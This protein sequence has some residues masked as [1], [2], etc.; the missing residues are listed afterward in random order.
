M[1]SRTVIK[2]VSA[3]LL[4]GAIIG[5]GVFAY[6]AGVAQGYA[7]NN[8]SSTGEPSQMPLP[9]YPSFYGPHFY[10]FGFLGC[11]VPFFL[12]FLIF[13]AMRGLFWGGWRDWG[14]MHHGPWGRGRPGQEM[15]PVFDEWHRQAHAQ[16]TS[17]A[18]EK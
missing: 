2:I 17:D 10:G 14:T 5:L 13:F 6:N 1:N 8:W 15:P 9:Y 11:L 18:S 7:I 4:V 12:I 3:L 16:P